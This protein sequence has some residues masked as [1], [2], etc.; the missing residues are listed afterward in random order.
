[1]GATYQWW[2]MLL[3]IYLPATVLVLRRP[4]EVDP[5]WTAEESAAERTNS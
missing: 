3:L 2:V 1:M 4:N 5:F